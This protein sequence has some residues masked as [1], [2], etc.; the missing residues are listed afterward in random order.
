MQY[1]QAIIFD[2]DGTLIHSAPD[3]RAAINLALSDIG[4]GPLDLE[5]TIRFIGNGVE[6]LVARSLA[7]TGGGDEVLAARVLDTFLQAY[8]RD[9][10]TLTRPY[11]GVIDCL[12][13]LRSEQL[14]LAICTNKPQG[15]AREICDLLDLSR[16]FDVIAG[17]VPELPKKP[18]P[19]PLL[20]VCAQ[21]GVPPQRVLYV[22]DSVVDFQTARA[23]DVPFR[24]FGG[25]YL[26]AP[27]PDLDPAHRFEKWSDVRFT[28]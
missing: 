16:F 21:L 24:L 27:L 18:D 26:N 15:P 20:A 19:A 9:K 23:A 1:P 13:A 4:R 6:V 7:H 3:L 17:A 5:T 22:G 10:V 14:P 28:L 8:H 12:S 25:G 2:L 11:S